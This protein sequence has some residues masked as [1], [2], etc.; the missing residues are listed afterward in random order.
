MISSAIAWAIPTP[1]DGGHL[2]VTLVVGKVGLPYL[3]VDLCRVRA[4]RPE[5]ELSQL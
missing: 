4:R 3:P 1:A 2:F 5:R